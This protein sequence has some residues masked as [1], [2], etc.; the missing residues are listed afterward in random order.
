M[1]GLVATI[2]SINKRLSALSNHHSI[3]TDNHCS[4]GP[5]HLNTRQ[6]DTQLQHHPKNYQGIQSTTVRLSISSPQ[7][8]QSEQFKPIP[9]ITSARYMKTAHTTATIFVINEQ[10]HSLV[11]LSTH[12]L[13][14]LIHS[15]FKATLD[16]TRT[17]YIVPSSSK[18]IINEYNHRT[19]HPNTPSL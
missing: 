3:S 19:S 12:H 10:N 8:M 7:T 15:N 9:T 2:S 1:I 5:L 13:A 11:N 14:L 16:N 6:C 18:I 17:R 4:L